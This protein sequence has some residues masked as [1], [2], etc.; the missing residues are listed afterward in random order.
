MFH[1][2][3]IISPTTR[4]CVIIFSFIGKVVASDKAF[5]VQKSVEYVWFVDLKSRF[6]LND[7]SC[8]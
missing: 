4:F 8:G 7:Y 6:Q 1:A 3:K 5:H 2:Y